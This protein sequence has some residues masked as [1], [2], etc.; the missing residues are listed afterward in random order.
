MNQKRG[1]GG[2][3]RAG[4]IPLL[5]TLQ[6]KFKPPSRAQLELVDAALAI[7][8]IITVL[9]GLAEFE[10]DL[11]RSRTGEGRELAKKR[12]VKFGRPSKLTPHQRREAIARREQGELLTEIARTYNVSDSTISRL[13]A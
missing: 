5:K 3:V 13:R 7:Q 6:K 2:L 8:V 1:Q 10:R 9:A 4:E 11:I 12:G